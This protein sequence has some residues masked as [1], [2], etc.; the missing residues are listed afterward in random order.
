MACPGMSQ[1]SVNRSRCRTGESLAAEHF[2][3]LLKKQV[4]GDGDALTLVGGKHRHGARPHFS[5]AFRSK[6]NSPHFGP[7]LAVNSVLLLYFA[8]MKIS[9]SST[10]AVGSLAALPAST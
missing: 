8:G 4:R 1:R 10:S 3:P 6:F 9:Y 2:G 5:S 7:I